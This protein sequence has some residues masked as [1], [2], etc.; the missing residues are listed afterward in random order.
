[1][2]QTVIVS[3]LTAVITVVL[4][5]VALNQ[6][7][8]GTVSS[9]NTPDIAGPSILPSSEDGQLQGDTDCD[10]DVDAVDGLG[11]L[12]DVA[13]LD[14][15]AQQEPCTDVGNLIP[16]GEGVP[17]P[18]GEQ[19][20]PGPAGPAGPQ[21]PAGL[22]GVEIVTGSEDYVAGP[23]LSATATCSDGKRVI[24]G[25]GAVVGSPMVN[26]VGLTDTEPNFDETG[27]VATAQPFGSNT[28]WSLTAYAIC[29]NV[30]E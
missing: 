20:V 10:G 29:A 26:D 19:G 23:A 16:L 17:G 13:A 22:S 18:Q 3:A 7:G 12:I 4:S 6:L 30:P 21:G 2:R 14:A 8:A 11:V 24:G 15:L 9:A 25:G 28:S 1:M 27:W 5:V